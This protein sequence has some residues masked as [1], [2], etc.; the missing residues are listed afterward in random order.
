MFLLMLATNAAVASPPLALHFSDG[1]SDTAFRI[2]T[3]ASGNFYI[4]AEL[5]ES[6]APNRPFAVIKYS[7]LGQRQWVF[8]FPR[9]L[10]GA[11]R[12]VQVDAAGNVYAAGFIANFDAT[13]SISTSGLVVSLNSAGQQ[14]WARSFNGQANTLALD[15]SGNVYVGGSVDL[16]AGSGAST[17]WSLAKYTTAG[18]LLWQRQH[19]GT[20]NPRLAFAPNRVTALALDPQQNLIVLGQTANSGSRFNT[21][22][23]TVVKYGPQGNSL[24]TRDF[25]DPGTDQVVPAALAVDQSGSVYV[26]GDQGDPELSPFPLTVKYDTNGNFRFELKGDGAG[27]AS[28]AVDAGGNIVLAGFSPTPG[29]LPIAEVAKIDASGHPLWL[30]RLAQHND[31]FSQRKILIDPAG[32]ILS[33]G[34]SQNFGDGSPSDFLISKLNT[35]G[36]ELGQFRFSPAING[37]SVSDAALDPFGNL[38]VTGIAVNAAFDNDIYTLRIPQNF[39]FPGI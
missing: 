35:N 11:A 10:S 31:F 36:V 8:H 17:N 2:A 14:R 39:V 7:A 34:T 24:W 28:V 37:S 3:D 32:N 23:I 15:G 16:S 27:G 22:A 12:A 1:G 33:A 13:G 21:F 38:L 26:T 9:Q 20:L 29:V 6:T 18:Q 25:I 30:T 19:A 4:A 5:D